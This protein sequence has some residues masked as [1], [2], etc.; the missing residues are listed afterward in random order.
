L[1]SLKGGRFLASCRSGFTPKR[2][3]NS[4]AK[5]GGELT[6]FTT[7]FCRITT[8]ISLP[9]DLGRLRFSPVTDFLSATWRL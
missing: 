8:E 7:H 4:V 9:G 2:G 3:K 5:K 1:E 6:H